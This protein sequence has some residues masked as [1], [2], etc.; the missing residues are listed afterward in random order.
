MSTTML[1]AL[2]MGAL[3]PLSLA[4]ANVFEF[5]GRRLRRDPRHDKKKEELL[6]H[7]ADVCL[8][9]AWLLFG[10]AY[11]LRSISPDAAAMDGLFQ[12]WMTWVIVALLV[13]DIPYLFLRRSRPRVP[14]RKKN[15]WEI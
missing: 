5:M 7:R 10:A 8:V 12:S 4:V 14:G 1:L 13:L 15:F 2:G 6:T 9:A 11:L 3:G